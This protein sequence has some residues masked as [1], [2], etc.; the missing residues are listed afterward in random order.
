[1][2]KQKKNKGGKAGKKGKAVKGGT[3]EP[4]AKAK[5]KSEPSKLNVVFAKAQ[6]TKASYF[7]AVSSAQELI[8]GLSE[9]EHSWA[10]SLGNRVSEAMVTLVAEPQKNAFSKDVLR[11]VGKDLKKAHKE[12]IE[13]AK[14]LK[15]FSDEVGQ[16]VDALNDAVFKLQGHMRVG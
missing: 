3:P 14:Q 9:P 11:M 6:K 13:F 1:M 12:E 8:N 16:K 5:A 2:G 15:D 7:A 10:A 4:K